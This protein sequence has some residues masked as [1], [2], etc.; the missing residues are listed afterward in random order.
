MGGVH[1]LLVAREPATF[2]GG[3]IGGATSLWDLEP[4]TA[5]AVIDDHLH[6]GRTEGVEEAV[7]PGHTLAI[8]WV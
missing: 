4:G 3:G 1:V 7:Q 2:A 8:M 6:P 5:T